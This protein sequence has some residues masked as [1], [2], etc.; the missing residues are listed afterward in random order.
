MPSLK[1]T[2]I[3]TF[4]F[5]TK[6]ALL[7]LITPC[8]SCTWTNNSVSYRMNK[9]KET[10]FRDLS[11]WPLLSL[12]EICTLLPHS[13]YQSME[14]NNWT[15]LLL[16]AITFRSMILLGCKKWSGALNMCT[17]ICSQAMFPTKLFEKCILIYILTT[18]RTF[19]RILSQSD[20]PR[21]PLHH[22]LTP[23]RYTKQPVLLVN[24]PRK[25][26]R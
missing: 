21:Q 4:F 14:L 5:Q 13:E 12:T 23:K 8:H 15:E 11:F 25:L 2:C 10:G 7:R 22:H 20:I 24:C 19:L 9:E 6:E 26:N 18:S 3:K 1:K 17:W 16:Q